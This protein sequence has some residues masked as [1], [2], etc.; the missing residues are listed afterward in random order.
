M[1]KSLCS[2]CTCVHVWGKGGREGEGRREAG[3][4]G[5]VFWSRGRF[6]IILVSPQPLTCLQKGAQEPNVELSSIR[7]LIISSL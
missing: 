1:E 7:L 4:G 6:L 3:E 5:K 2:L